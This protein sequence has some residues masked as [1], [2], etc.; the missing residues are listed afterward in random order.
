VDVVYGA[1]WATT[2]QALEQVGLLDEQF[3]FF[4]EDLDWCKR[5]HD[6]GWNVVY[7]PSAQAIHYGGASSS[8]K[9]IKF[10]IEKQ[11]SALLYWRK[12]Y[13]ISGQLYFFFISAL[14]DVL[15]VFGYSVSW[16]F[17]PKSRE[18]TKYMVS[19]SY[20]SLKWMVIR[21]S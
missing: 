15:R 8:K 20:A 14:R 9:P 4:G 6:T 18:K 13:G 21:R 1:L 3:F 11:R 2:R 19:R 5:F 16:L 10:Y 7:L 17:Y 12:H